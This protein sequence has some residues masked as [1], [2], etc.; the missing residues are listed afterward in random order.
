M[1]D[2]ENCTDSLEKYECFKTMFHEVN[3]KLVERL[4]RKLNATQASQLKFATKN[5]RHIFENAPASAYTR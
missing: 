5:A 4:G 2:Y 3:G 1:E